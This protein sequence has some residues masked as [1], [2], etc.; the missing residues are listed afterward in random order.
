MCTDYRHQDK[1]Q[2]RTETEVTLGKRIKMK[3][4]SFYL[5]LGSHLKSPTATATSHSATWLDLWVDGRAIV[6]GPFTK[7]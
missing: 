4:A 7:A 3:N 1:K 2:G 5:R 6:F